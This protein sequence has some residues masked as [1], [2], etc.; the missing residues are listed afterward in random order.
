M[1]DTG[2]ARESARPAAEPLV[3]VVDDNGD[4]RA[5][6]AHALRAAGYRTATAASA[7]DALG[8]LDA[9][10]PALVVLDLV[11]PGTDGF[12]AAR[13]IRAR[14]V[15]ANVPILLFTALGAQAATAAR[16]AGATAFLTK[17]VEPRALVA[18]V[19]RLCP[20]G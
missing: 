8:R 9:L 19:R 7:E 3:L 13:A 5:I 11:M 18:E 10:R 6:C 2:D 15:G 14:A 20:A 17:P 4:A 12:T 16:A 1:S